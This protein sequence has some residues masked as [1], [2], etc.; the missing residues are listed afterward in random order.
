MKF[1]AKLLPTT[2]GSLP[3]H[4]PREACNKILEYTPEI[5]AW[6]QLPKLR[7]QENM[8]AQFAYDIPGMVIDEEGRRVFLRASESSH[9]QLERFYKDILAGDEGKFALSQKYF[10][11]FYEMLKMLENHSGTILAKGQLTG[12]FSLALKITDE[13]NK[14]I[15]Y[16]PFYGEV[17]ARSLNLKAKW[18]QKTLRGL[19]VSTLIVFDE[20]YLSMIGSA[21]VSL[22]RERIVRLIHDA[23]GDLDGLLGVHCC[24]NTDW[25]L[26]LDAPIDYLSVDAYNYGHTLALYSQKIERF[27]H[28]GGIIGW[29]IVPSTDDALAGEN[30]ESLLAKLKEGMR[31]LEKKGVNYGDILRNSLITPSC[32]LGGMSVP[33]AEKALAFTRELSDRM[34]MEY[35]LED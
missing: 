17:I 25:G 18:M 10:S 1:E 15:V 5:P 4:V 32:G 26:L 13:K 2:V 33:L 8:Y 35:S 7:F 11:G 20:P 31:G 6:P 3:H 12:P 14:P 21:F 22:S 9:V 29:G 27:L 23:L 28:N 16:D 24:G 19:Q 34:R 30:V